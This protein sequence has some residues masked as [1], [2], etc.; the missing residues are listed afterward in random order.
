MDRDEYNELLK[1]YY[2]ENHSFIEKAVFTVTASAITFLLGY[3][4]NISSNF[5][6][7]YALSIFLFILTLIIQLVSA[8]VSREGCDAGLDESQDEKSCKYFGTSRVLNNIFMITF[9]I[10][11][12]WT[13]IVI[14]MNSCK[15]ENINNYKFEQNI[16]TDSYEYSERRVLMSKKEYNN[17]VNPP[18]PLQEKYQGGFNPPKT[19]PP[20]KP[21][22]PPKENK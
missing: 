4:S 2:L 12:L 22:Q 16:K 6:S 21:V 19:T 11:I 15:S 20:P 1:K 3:F 5:V 9:C 7:W 10:A 13:S 14:I 18:K 8:Y 17:G